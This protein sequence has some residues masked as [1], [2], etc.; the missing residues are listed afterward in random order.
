MNKN[1]H[2]NRP[3]D[4]EGKDKIKQDTPPSY[5]SHKVDAV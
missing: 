3:F 5:K 1:G 2:H 4:A